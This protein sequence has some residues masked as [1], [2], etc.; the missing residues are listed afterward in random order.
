MMFDARFCDEHEDDKTLVFV[1]V[2]VFNC[3]VCLFV[4]CCFLERGGEYFQNKEDGTYCNYRCKLFYH[5]CV[6]LLL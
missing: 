6:L 2:D 4:C 3:F 5:D 1:C